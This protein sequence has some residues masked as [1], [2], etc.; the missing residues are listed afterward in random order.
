MKTRIALISRSEEMRRYLAGVLE[1]R[2]HEVEL[3]DDD[4]FVGMLMASAGPLIVWDMPALSEEHLRG[5]LSFLLNLLSARTSTGIRRRTP[6]LVLV[7]PA[8][9]SYLSG[10]LYSLRH[11]EYLLK[12]LNVTDFLKRVGELAESAVGTP[13][14]A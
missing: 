10:Y 11:E 14:K 13:I 9:T 8:Q 6:V 4:S 12:P 2:G 5:R 1:F 7:D 3:H